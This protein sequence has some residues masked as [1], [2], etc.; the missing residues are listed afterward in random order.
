MKS[1]KPDGTV[2]PCAL[3]LGIIPDES[4]RTIRNPSV[5]EVTFSF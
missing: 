5:Q 4:K 2:S 3:V 1:E